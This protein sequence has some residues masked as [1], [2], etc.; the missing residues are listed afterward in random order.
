MIFIASSAATRKSLKD[1]AAR[2]FDC[3]LNVSKRYCV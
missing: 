1:F 2:S 3:K